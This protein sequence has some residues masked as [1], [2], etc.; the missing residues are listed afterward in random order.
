METPHDRAIELADPARTPCDAE[1]APGKVEERI[2]LSSVKAIATIRKPWLIAVASF[3]AV[4]A[5][6][7]V[8][9]RTDPPSVFAP[10]SMASM[11]ILAFNR[12]Y[13]WCQAVFRAWT[14]RAT[15]SGDDHPAKRLKRCLP[16]REIEATYSIDAR[17]EGVVSW[18][19]TLAD[20]P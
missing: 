17:A 1:P 6:A 4:I 2:G 10:I 7:V 12:Q 20:Q 18:R 16:V 14:P 3:A 9:L 8:A 13:R 5:V 11:R 19:S 15:R